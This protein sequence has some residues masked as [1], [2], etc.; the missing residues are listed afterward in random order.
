MDIQK[1]GKEL[2]DW[3]ADQLP[4]NKLIGG[5]GGKAAEAVDNPVLRWSFAGLF[6]KIPEKHHHEVSNIVDA[7]VAGDSDALVDGGVEWIVEL[8]VTPLGDVK[9]RIIARNLGNMLRELVEAP[10]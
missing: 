3:V 4:F 9:E 1:K 5:L 6:K 8:I 2:G 7:I 10:E